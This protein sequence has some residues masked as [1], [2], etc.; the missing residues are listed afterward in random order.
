MSA[1]GRSLFV[2]MRSPTA[3]TSDF[4][5]VDSLY[6]HVFNAIP[7]SGPMGLMVLGGAL[8]G[9]FRRRWRETLRSA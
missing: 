1:L 5:R 9:V 6:V 3:V 2:E 8:L 4:A 7:E